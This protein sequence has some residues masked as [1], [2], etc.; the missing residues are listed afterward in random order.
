MLLAMYPIEGPPFYTSKVRA[1]VVDCDCVGWMPENVPPPT[2][3]NIITNS[4]PHHELHDVAMKENSIPTIFTSSDCSS[5]YET[6]E[7]N[8]DSN[9]KKVI[10]NFFFIKF[11]AC[12]ENIP[13][14]TESNITTNSVPHHESHNVLTINSI[15]VDEA[16]RKS[17]HNVS[18]ITMKTLHNSDNAER[19]LT[20][21]QFDCTTASPVCKSRRI[22]DHD[23]HYESSP[24]TLRRRLFNCEQRLKEKE[25]I[26]KLQKRKLNR[27][28]RKA[29]SFREMIDE[30]RSSMKVQISE[31]CLRSL[32]SIVDPVSKNFCNVSLIMVSQ[33]PF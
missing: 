8:Y 25:K 3:S 9:N 11:L 7:R 4:V 26:I 27:L 32:Q 24:T 10:P 15:P 22:I 28:H 14:A 20:S 21:M 23:H 17:S 16:R 2:E 18:D 5:L 13:P 19:G 6:P 1:C 29:S 33:T 12:K 31:A 30:L